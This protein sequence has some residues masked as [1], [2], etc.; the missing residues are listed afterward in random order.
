MKNIK[1]ILLLLVVIGTSSIFTAI[2]HADFETASFKRVDIEGIWNDV[3]TDGQKY[4]MVGS[5]GT[6]IVVSYDGLKW[7]QAY[8][9][10]NNNFSIGSVLWDGNKFIAP[11]NASVMLY[12]YDG[13]TWEESPLDYFFSDYEIFY[14]GQIYIVGGFASNSSPALVYSNDGLNWTRIPYSSI[15]SSSSKNL[16]NTLSALAWNGKKYVGIGTG[17]SIFSSTDT[18][19]WSEMK[20]G[21]DS[22]R[23]IIW[24]GKQFI[25]NYKE[26][27][28]DLSNQI[29][30]SK[31]GETWTKV[32]VKMD[33]NILEIKYTNNKYYLL[34]T[35]S[36]F[37]TEKGWV[38]QS[39]L[40]VSTDL[41]NWKRFDNVPQSIDGKSYIFDFVILQN[42]LFL[43]C[44]DSI[45][46]SVEDM[47]KPS[48]W[49]IPEIEK[50]NSYDLVPDRINFN[51]TKS[52]TREE[53]CEMVVRMYEK[54]TGKE[55]IT[56]I[57]NPFSDTSNR[58]ILKAYDLKI[59]NGTS[60]NRF[61]PNKSITRQEIAAM[62]YRTVK[63]IRQDIQ[64][65]GEAAFDDSNEFASWAKEA[66]AYLSSENIIKGYNNK[67]D[68]N[69]NTSR[70]QTISMILRLYEK[71][72][73]NIN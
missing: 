4:V 14:D 40:M 29:I 31:D 41:I 28:S 61:Q 55:H 10:P 34:G 64:I 9:A 26:N 63:L 58:Q 3:A 71:L 72:L 56:N 19:N 65:Q 13:L 35:K 27:T 24:D 53:F 54:L 8:T 43:L 20:Y 46:V 62:L 23:G 37:D 32:P 49:A 48:A 6:G 21:T 17:G 7:T 25:T 12:S 22:R 1:I 60:P 33:F 57:S 39:Y 70:E 50:A 47:K 36:D 2:S 18:K 51:Y 11:T 16:G 68:P 15:K 42:K 30:T 73:S 45:Y 66:I 52:I 67:F 38:G 59:V 5:W 69:S 44:K